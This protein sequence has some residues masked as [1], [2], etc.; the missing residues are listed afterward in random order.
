MHKRRKVIKQNTGTFIYL[1]KKCNK[2][3]KK[4]SDKKAFSHFNFF[5]QKKK[6]LKEIFQ[7]KRFL[8][9]LY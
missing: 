1:E 6:T 9:M 5:Y 8:I 3:K 2:R 7:T 4:Q